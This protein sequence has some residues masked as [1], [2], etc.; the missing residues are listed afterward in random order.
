MFLTA[1]DKNPPIMNLNGYANINRKLISS[2]VTS[3]ATYLVMLMQFRL[4]LMRKAA[5]ASRRAGAANFTVTPTAAP[6][7]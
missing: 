2:T 3:G 5:I 7:L 1:I 4:S 6:V